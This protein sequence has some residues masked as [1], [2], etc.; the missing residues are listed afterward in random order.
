MRGQGVSWFSNLPGW[1]ARL[2]LVMM[3]TLVI[4][5]GVVPSPRPHLRPAEPTDLMLYRAV[6][7]RVA[8]GENY[9]QAAAAEQRA[10]SFPTAPAPVFREPTLAW[11][12]A[13]L[14]TDGLRRAAIIGLSLITL[15]ALMEALARSIAESKRRVI[16]GLFIGTAI[17]TA[18]FSASPY[19][20]EVW[21]AL[22]IAL[23]LASYRLSHWGVSVLLGLAACLFRELALPFLGAMAI[24]ALYERKYR[25]L[26][27]WIAG[28]A[29]F[30]GLFGWHWSV[31][32]T[33]HQP[34]DLVSRGWL[35]LGGW[36]FVIQT[37]KMNSVLLL[38][39]KFVIAPVVCLAIIG[40]A[41][42]RDPWL[43]RVAFIVCGYLASFAIVGRPDNLYWGLLISP[44][45]PVGVVLSPMPIR[46]LLAAAW[47]RQSGPLGRQFAR[48]VV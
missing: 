36:P 42:T 21:A 1:A 18:W 10:R 26:A 22:L 2:I 8:H 46:D 7:G 39:P 15:I 32:A 19:F 48:S 41:G 43:L 29:V 47:G 23:S 4:S 3:A 13:A 12:L 30:C 11:T 44:L 6:V 17:S 38:A 28:I 27:G 14:K 9:Y 33:L 31:A 45:L 5:G 34:G 37:A 20:H 24:F 35:G 40:F 16:A 25:E